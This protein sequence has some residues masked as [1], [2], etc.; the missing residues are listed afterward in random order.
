MKLTMQYI[1]LLASLIISIN[2]SAQ[3]WEWGKA[4]LF[5]KDAVSNNSGAEAISVAT[6][7]NGNVYET[8]WIFGGLL[9]YGN[10][11]IKNT[12]SGF[13]YNF[14]VAKY[15]ANGVFQWVRQSNNTRGAVWGYSI[16]TDPWGN[17][18]AGGTLFD[19]VQFGNTTLYGNQL[20]SPFLIK[21]DANGNQLWVRSATS[22][23]IDNGW[24][25]ATDPSGNV[26]ISGSFSDT[27]TFGTNTLIEPLG[28][29]DLFLAKYDS[30]GNSI[31]ARQGSNI[32]PNSSSYAFGVTSD[33]QN[34]IYVTGYFSHTIAIGSTQLTTS[35]ASGD[36]FTAKYDVNGN[37][38]WAKQSISHGASG[39]DLV[40]G[41]GIVADK[42]G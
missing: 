2:I 1:F 15:D 39:S 38:L 8:G 17:V 22:D 21:Y 10:D 14:Y 26:Y 11:T 41:N 28:I 32:L 27:I 42:G 35:S 25:I 34:N 5:S 30:A 6:D 19:T 4:P 31:W 40:A 33:M 13:N 16:A 23:F 37:V 20:G 9:M 18:Y 36:V 29:T 7:N 3:N 12:V 24:A